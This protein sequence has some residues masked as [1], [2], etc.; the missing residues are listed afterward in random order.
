MKRPK[1]LSAA[2]VKTVKEP[3]RYGDGRG[4]HGLS[5]L[6]KESTTGRLS[7]SWSQRLRING[8]PFNIGLGGYPVITLAKAREVALENRR[9]VA[10]GIDLRIPPRAIPTFSD[11]I[12]SVIAIRSES[13]KNAKT[14]KKWRSGLGTYAVPLLGHKLVSEVSSADVMAVLTPIWGRET[15][16]RQAGPGTN[17]IDHGMGD[18]R[19][20]SD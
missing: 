1:Q 13:W 19:G 8:Q 4:G 2:F 16:D 5:M 6:V 18:C 3:G 10:D 15:G 11:A 20:A 12:E 17:L 7:K 9:A 14:E